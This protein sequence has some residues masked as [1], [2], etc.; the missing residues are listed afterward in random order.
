MKIE[1]ILEIIEA[2]REIRESIE[3]CAERSAP[4]HDEMRRMTCER[5][6]LRIERDAILAECERMRAERKAGNTDED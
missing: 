3:L 1:Y 2:L 4:L 6:K 5:D